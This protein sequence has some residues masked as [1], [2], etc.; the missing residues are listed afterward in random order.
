MGR[1]ESASKAV[2]A[3]NNNR[4]KDTTD[5][6]RSLKAAIIKVQQPQEA[7]ALRS[8]VAK[9]TQFAA[10][11]YSERPPNFNPNTQS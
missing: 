11:R 2:I 5:P 8:Q 4:Q 9:E 3:R 10:L 1:V 6:E 7:S